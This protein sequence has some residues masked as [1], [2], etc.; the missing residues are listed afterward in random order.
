[1]ADNHGD[2]WVQLVTF[3]SKNPKTPDA[4]HGNVTEMEQQMLDTLRSAA[5]S[6]SRYPGSSHLAQRARGGR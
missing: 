4:F 2:I 3:A 5:R 6:A 1:M